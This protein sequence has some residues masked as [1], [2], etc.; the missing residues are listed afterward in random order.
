MNGADLSQLTMG[1]QAVPKCSMDQAE[2][3]LEAHSPG[4][5]MRVFKS[6]PMEAI[7]RLEAVVSATSDRQ[8]SSC[9]I[10]FRRSGDLLVALLERF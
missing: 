2:K 7:R 10:S 9:E 4:D 6:A 1:S 8:L 5:P 3:T